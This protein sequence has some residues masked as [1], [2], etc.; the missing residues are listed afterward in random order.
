MKQISFK[1]LLADVFTTQTSKTTQEVTRQ[2]STPVHGKQTV[3]RNTRSP[4]PEIQTYLRKHR[5]LSFLDKLYS[6]IKI[7]FVS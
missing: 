5:N 7:W 2:P 6:T 4:T 1:N 3:G